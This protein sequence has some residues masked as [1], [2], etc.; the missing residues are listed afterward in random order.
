ML[1]KPYLDLTGVSDKELLYIQ[2]DLFPAAIAYL[3]SFLKVI[4]DEAP[5]AI[6]VKECGD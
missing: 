3:E 5:I 6:E 4:R 1:K 2:Y